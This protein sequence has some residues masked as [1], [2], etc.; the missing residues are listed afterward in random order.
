MNRKFFKLGPKASVFSDHSN[1][2]KVTKN[3]PG[4]TI[5]STKTK[6]T[7]AA[8]GDGH[9]QEIDE[10]TYLE[11]MNSDAVS[12]KERDLAFE[13]QGYDP[14]AKKKDEEPSEEPSEESKKKKK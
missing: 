8:I 3:I 2:L 1:G 11:L 6:V 14:K 4:S 7:S 10:K 12:S 9:I 13:E 5:K